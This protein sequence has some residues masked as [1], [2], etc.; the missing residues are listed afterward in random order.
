MRDALPQRES[1]ILT[2][3]DRINETIMISLRTMEGLDLLAF[4]ENFGA[5]ERI[6]LEGG[7]KK[8]I[9]QQLL[10]VDN[11]RAFLLDEGM[12]AADGIAAKLF[13]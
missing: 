7:M 1:E 2:R 4:E 9:D 13:L 10:V 6:R 8:Y 12:L 11:N 5:D 3:R